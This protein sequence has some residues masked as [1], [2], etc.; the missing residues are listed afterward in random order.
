MKS[1]R[2][3][4]VAL[5]A[6]AV[7]NCADQG[8]LDISAA[9][10]NPAAIKVSTAPQNDLLGGVTG[11]VGGLVQNLGLLKCT[12]LPPLTASA[13]IG[14]QGGTLAIGPHVLVVAPGALSSTVTI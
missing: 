5:L 14:P 10:S 7:A 8:P 2:V 9:R 6:F 11:L 1:T 12:P 4:L 13:A 3:L